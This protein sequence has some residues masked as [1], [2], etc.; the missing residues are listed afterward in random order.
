MILKK[1][2]LIMSILFL[3]ISI[4]YMICSKNTPLVLSH[5][6][7]NI[8]QWVKWGGLAIAIVF[9]GI[10]VVIGTIVMVATLW[11]ELFEK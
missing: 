9:V 5:L 1:N 3:L 11:S 10:F 4:L 8:I 7:Y 2:L 6:F